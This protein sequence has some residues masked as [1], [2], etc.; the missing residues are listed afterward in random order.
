M[1]RLLVIVNH[2]ESQPGLLTQLMISENIEFDLRIGGVSRLPEPSSLSDYDGL[3]MLGGGYMP[4]ETDRAPWLD[5]EAQLSRHAL[6]ADLPQFGICLGGQL[7][8]HVIGGDVRAQTGAP[9][10][11]Y[12]W[13]DM[14]DNAAQDPVFSSIG[15]RAAF[16]ESHVDRIV[17]LPPEAT[18]LAT[19][20]ACR[21][22]AFRIGNAWGTQFHPESSGQ[23][24]RNWDAEKLQEL[25]FNK[26]TLLEQAEERGED[27]QRD[28]KVLLTAFL[29]VV[30][31][32]HK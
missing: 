29:D 9:E 32:R 17:D 26:D 27:S 1:T 30:R 5:A 23:N 13:I 8:A 24:I 7:I 22:Q 25:G 18:L 12:T 6:E 2:I 14:T 15:T 3:I 19:S 11:G 10:K 4:D 16:V 31:S 20:T 28:A 21:F